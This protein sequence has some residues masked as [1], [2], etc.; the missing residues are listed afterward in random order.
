MKLVALVLPALLALSAAYNTSVTTQFGSVSLQLTQ[1]R[2]GEWMG[3]VNMTALPGHRPTA[4]F[5]LP[6]PFTHTHANGWSARIGTKQTVQV[7]CN[8]QGLLPQLK[9]KS[10]Y[11]C[12]NDFGEWGLQFTFHD[13]STVHSQQATFDFHWEPVTT[14]TN[15]GRTQPLCNCSNSSDVVPTTAELVSGSKR[16]TNPFFI[17]LL[18]GGICALSVAVGWFAALFC[19]KRRLAALQQGA[20]QQMNHNAMVQQQHA[21]QHAHAMHQMH[22]QVP[23]MKPDL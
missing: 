10:Q 2:N 13:V 21:L 6:L 12:A 15:I 14:Q 5:Y 16:H 7:M 18:I 17:G 19:V 23:V 1:Q 4:E 20:Y 22:M 3:Q 11:A 8:K 9:A